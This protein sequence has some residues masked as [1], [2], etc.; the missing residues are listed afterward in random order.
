MDSSTSPAVDRRSAHRRVGA[1]AILAF[2]ALLLFGAT[3]GPAQA[4]PA[5]P[6]ATPA[7]TDPAQP[8]PDDP[9]PGFRD[10]HGGPGPRGDGDRDGGG[11]G[12]GDPGGGAAPA[13]AP[14]TGGNQT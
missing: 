5:V 10:D 11:F 7:A 9:G 14:S 2:L 3:R 4:D 8:L 13:P 1:A 6:V 12:G